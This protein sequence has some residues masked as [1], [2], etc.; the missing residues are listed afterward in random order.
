MINGILYKNN[1]FSPMSTKNKINLVKKNKK[2]EINKTKDNMSYLQNNNNLENINNN[3]FSKINKFNNIIFFKSNILP[4]S[5]RILS[6]NSSN[7]IENKNHENKNHTNKNFKFNKT[8]N[9]FDSKLNNQILKT[10]ENMNKLDIEIIDKN[11][12]KNHLQK[13]KKFKKKILVLDLDET[14]IHTF[15]HPINNADIQLNIPIYDDINDIE[16]NKIYVKKRP[17]LDLFL[18]ELKKYYN[19]YIFSSS[20][21]D[22]VSEITKEIDKDKIIIKYFSEKDCLTVPGGGHYNIYIKD[23]TKINNDLSNMVIV[24]D[25]ITSFSLQ[26]DNGIPI[27]PWYGEVQDKELF[28]LIHLLKKLVCY[29]DVRIEIKKLVNDNVL[30]WNKCLQWLKSGSKKKV[31]NNVDFDKKLKI[32]ILKCKSKICNNSRYETNSDK[33]HYKALLSSINNSNIKYK[34]FAYR[35][36]LYLKSNDYSK[37]SK[38]KNNFL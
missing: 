9:S 36:Q 22:Y 16:I 31:A 28:K 32:K 24:D 34:P 5:S 19:I 18:K 1:I 33:I 37:S 15:L 8:F 35:Y 2:T 25:N 14:L 23:L 7:A 11:T 12:K 30:S 38:I 21:V 20:P 26:S 29:K 4:G 17:G 13:F 6:K 27:K 3:I 10:V